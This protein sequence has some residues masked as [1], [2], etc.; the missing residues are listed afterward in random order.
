M[1]LSDNMLNF[2]GYLAEK[3]SGWC[4]TKM[5]IG[6]AYPFGVKAAVKNGLIEP[7]IFTLERTNFDLPPLPG[8]PYGASCEGYRLTERGRTVGEQMRGRRCRLSRR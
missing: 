6:L 4:S 3:P 5:A 7:S 8:F 1:K 2:L